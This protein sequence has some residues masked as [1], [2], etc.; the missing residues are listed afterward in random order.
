M[1]FSEW[2]LFIVILLCTFMVILLWK[3]IFFWIEFVHC[4]IAM[5]I[6]GDII[7]KVCLFFWIVFVHCNVTMY[8]H[9]NI[10]MKVFLF[11]E[12]SLFIV[13]LLCCYESVF[14]FWIEFVHCNITIYIHINITMNV[15]FSFNCVFSLQYYFVHPQEY[16]YESVPVFWLR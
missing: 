3:C 4:N 14:F 6:H 10:T 16:Y 12:L 11:S 1:S 7:M 5:Y 15:C 9:G 2:S 13:I 8:I